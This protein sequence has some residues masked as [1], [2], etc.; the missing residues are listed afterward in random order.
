MSN[1]FDIYSKAP[2]LTAFTA[3]E[4]VEKALI[5]II[6]KFEYCFFISEISSKKLPSGSFTSDIIKSG[7]RSFKTRLRPDRFPVVSTW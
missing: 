2:Y 6:G 4:R 7:T 5:I 3:V 1:G